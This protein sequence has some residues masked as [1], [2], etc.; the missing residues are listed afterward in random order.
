MGTRTRTRIALLFSL[1]LVHVLALAACGHQLAVLEAPPA[2]AYRTLG[3]VSGQGE[4]ESSAMHMAVEQAR[5]IDADAVVIEG[6]RN[7][8]S[9]CIVTARAI[10]Y[11]E[12]PPP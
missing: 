10:K 1:A 9:A 7:V 6:R 4:N 3:M 5:R 12:A 11:T 8:G 2:T